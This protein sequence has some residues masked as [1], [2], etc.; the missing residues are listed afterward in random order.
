MADWP[1]PDQALVL[2]GTG[3]LGRH[4]MS[5]LAEAGVQCVSASRGEGTDLR[6]VAATRELLQCHQPGFVV[7]CAAHVGSLHYVTRQAADVVLDNTLMTLALYQA[8]MEACPRAVIINPIANCAYPATVNTLAEDHWW[9]GHLHPSVFSFGSTRRMLWS[10]AEC[11]WMQHGVRSINF[12]VP[13]MYGPHGSTDPDK[14]HALNALISR[15]VRAQRG[16]ADH[17][18]VWGTG[19]AIREWLYARDLAELV[20]RV[21]RKPDM[22]GLSEPLN[23]AQNCGLSVRELVDLIVML[24]GFEGLVTYDHSMPDGVPRK[25]M[26]D[27]RFRKVFPDFEFTALNEGV[28]SSIAYYRSLPPY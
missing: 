3:F 18:T 22:R 9:D 6:E 23:I 24:T 11:F 4:V 7:N 26:D 1:R 5:V 12:L 21:I 27:R 13:N 10:V 20:L 19:A 17:V 8:A 15:F 16:G 2:G 28:E 14:A 25:V